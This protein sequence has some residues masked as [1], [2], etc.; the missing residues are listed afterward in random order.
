[1][2]TIYL[3]NERFRAGDV[4]SEDPTLIV[5]MIDS[6]GI[7]FSTNSIGHRLEARIDGSAKSIHLTEFY[8]G[9]TD[10]YQSGSAEMPLTG[11]S[12]GNHTLKVRCMGCIQ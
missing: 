12:D 5:S 2:I 4:V 9:K 11:L 6:S 10:S 7:N 8:K 3:D 1:M